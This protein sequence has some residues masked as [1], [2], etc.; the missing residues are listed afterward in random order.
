MTSTRNIV[1][2][3]TAAVTAIVATYG[4]QVWSAAPEGYVSSLVYVQPS[5][6]VSPASY[7]YEDDDN[8]TDE[9]PLVRPPSPEVD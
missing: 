9:M 2:G 3:L 7:T 1:I 6:Y 8:D 5:S 4:Y